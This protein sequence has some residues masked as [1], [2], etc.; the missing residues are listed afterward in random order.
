M[1][2]A[3]SDSYGVLSTTGIRY[4]EVVGQLL[5]MPVNNQGQSG[6]CNRRILRTSTRDLLQLDNVYLAVICLAPLTRGEWWNPRKVPTNNDGH[7]ESFQISNL[8]LKHSPC[9]DY[10]N[11]WYRLY[12]DE[13]E[14]TN[15]F[16]ELILFTGWL[17]SRGVKYLIFSGN[18]ATIKKIDPED[19]FLRDFYHTLKDDPGVLDLYDFSFTKFCLSKG[20]RPFDYD[21][22]GEYGH[23]GETAHRDFARYLLEEY[24]RR[25]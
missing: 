18:N 15:L 1:I 6:S 9:A 25:Y 12:N 20:H 22:Y 19:V 11:H 13:A 23:H 7:F 21:S 17:K 16:S 5:D 3:N 2:Y 4:P 8:D 10:A 24:E 14:E